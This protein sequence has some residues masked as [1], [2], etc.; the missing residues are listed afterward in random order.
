M[1]LDTDV[2]LALLKV[3]DWLQDAVES[4]TFDS[5]KTS[6]ITAIEIQL[7][8]FDT[9]SRSDLAAVIADIRDEDVEVLTLTPEAFQAGADL[10]PAYTGLNVFDAVHVGQA[11]TLGEPIVSTD[12][13][14]PNIDEIE[15]L[16]PRSLC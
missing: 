6:V 10:L 7:V 11:I 3:D 15:Q 4:A 5:P 12:T 2:L 13:L 1:Y 16:D 8:M 9:W 14:Y